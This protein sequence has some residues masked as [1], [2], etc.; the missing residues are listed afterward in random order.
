LENLSFN[1]NNA[2]TIR[3]AGGQNDR[4]MKTVCGMRFSETFDFFGLNHYATKLIQST[5]QGV[6]YNLDAGVEE[7]SDTRWKS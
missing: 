5:T 2:T 7:I 3:K 1:F 6:F 4:I